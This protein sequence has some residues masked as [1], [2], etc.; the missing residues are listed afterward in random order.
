MEALGFSLRREAV[1]ESLTQEVLKSNEIEGKILDRDQVR[2][3][4][5]RRL[6]ID[7][8]GLAPGGSPRRRCRR[9]DVRR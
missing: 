3:S 9:N 1:L 6:G 4:I 8:G 7:V 2:S 5:A